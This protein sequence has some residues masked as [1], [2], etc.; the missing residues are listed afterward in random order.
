M[1][2]M[3][4]FPEEHGVGQP[5]QTPCQADTGQARLESLTYQIRCKLVQ[6]LCRTG[7]GCSQEITLGDAVRIS[8]PKLSCWQTLRL[9]I[10]VGPTRSDLCR[11]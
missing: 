10:I 7:F 4:G 5:F 9:E 8:R 3:A 6:A 2:F 11:L 1:R